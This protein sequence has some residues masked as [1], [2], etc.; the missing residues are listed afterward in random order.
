MTIGFQKKLHNNLNNN[1]Y[2]SLIIY[3][4]TFSIYTFFNYLC[5]KQTDDIL[6]NVISAL[7][8]IPFNNFFV[9]LF[10]GFSYFGNKNLKHFTDT[11]LGIFAV[12]MTKF[13]YFILMKNLVSIFDYKNI[14]LLS[15]SVVVSIFLTIYNFFFYI[16]TD[17]IEC[18]TEKLILFQFIFGL[19]VYLIMHLPFIISFVMCVF[20]LWI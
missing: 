16:I 9:I 10:S 2:I 11:F 18:N 13:Y 20:C 6:D 8:I 5:L 17:L 14:D 3:I 12:A 7:Y 1:D 4:I 19:I 15:N